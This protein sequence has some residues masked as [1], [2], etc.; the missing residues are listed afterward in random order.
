MEKMKKEN[1]AISDS[2]KQIRQQVRGVAF[3]TRRPRP[4]RPII[5]MKIKK[6]AEQGDADAQF[7]LGVLYRKGKKDNVYRPPLS[8][9]MPKPQ[10]NIGVSSRQRR[11]GRTRD[12][13]EGAKWYRTRRFSK[14]MP[15]RRPASAF[16]M[17]QN[18]TTPKSPNGYRLA[19]EQGNAKAQSKPRNF[20]LSPRRG[21]RTKPHRSRQMA[22]SRCLSKGMPI[23]QVRPRQFHITTARE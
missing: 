11:G 17:R 14:D 10:F 18:K 5:L 21:S 4:V 19:A 8:N 3:R 12:C 23:A 20:I 13:A 22:S 7:N 2:S 15:K 16:Y 1:T 6:K 9:Y